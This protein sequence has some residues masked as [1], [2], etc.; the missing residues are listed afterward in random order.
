[1]RVGR[2]L[3][4]CIPSPRANLPLRF[5]P[6]QLGQETYLPR[7]PRSSNFLIGPPFVKK[8]W[9]YHDHLSISLFFLLTSFNNPELPRP[10]MQNKTTPHL[11]LKYHPILDNLAI[12]WP[13]FAVPFIPP[14]RP[15][16]FLQDIQGSL[17]GATI[18]PSS[19]LR[20]KRK[21]VCR[22]GVVQYHQGHTTQP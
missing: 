15:S 4:A 9:K 17:S 6:R 13:R 16:L 12:T 20:R 18:P 8:S 14:S 5:L 11:S 1:M 7:Q 22:G 21:M 19:A 10:R 2:P 3:D